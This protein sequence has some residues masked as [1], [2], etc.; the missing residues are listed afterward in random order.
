MAKK[1]KEKTAQQVK[2]LKGQELAYR[3]QLNQLGRALIKAIKEELL[4][5][6]KTQQNT[7]VIDGKEAFQKSIFIG[8]QDTFN[9][10]SGIR[11]QLISKCLN[12]SRINFKKDLI[13]DSLGGD[14]ELIFS[15][16]TQQFTGTL[17]ASFANT[18]SEEM[19]K[20]TT[21]INKKKFDA[22]IQK[23]TGVDL[24][25]IVQTEGLDDFISLSVNK[26]VSL[27]KSLP[28][29]YL[30]QVETIVNNGV[31]S[32]ARFNTIAKE[33]QAGANKKL[34]GRIKTIA[35]NEIQTINSQINLRRSDSLGL[36][37]G[38]YRTSKDEKV[39]ESH[40]ELNGKR[41]FLKKGAWSKLA[42]KF[43]QPGITDIN[44]RCGYS[45]IIEVT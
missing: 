44:C 26:N 13:Y 11:K 42:Q 2:P 7:Y 29:E 3:K 17:V 4:P 16:L 39:R 5:Y 38:F 37:E 31:V 30:K 24:G 25:A 22:A 6:L 43:I 28:E 18:T 21:I 20:K 12:D 32:G 19:V 41:Y 27:I 14:L 40:K 36:K 8:I 34:A 45:P 1:K 33:I 9:C 10:I 35:M 23:A 15:R